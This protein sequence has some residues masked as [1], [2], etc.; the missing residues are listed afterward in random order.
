[1]NK[2]IIRSIKNR[3]YIKEWVN[4]TSSSRKKA[5]ALARD[6]GDYELR[7]ELSLLDKLKL[8][9][10]EDREAMVSEAIGSQSI[11]D[12]I[13]GPLVTHTFDQSP[14]M[15]LAKLFSLAEVNE[16]L[17]VTL[18]PITEESPSSDSCELI[19]NYKDQFNQFGLNLAQSLKQMNKWRCATFGIVL[20][21]IYLARRWGKDVP[22][23]DAPAT[24]QTVERLCVHYDFRT[25]SRSLD[26]VFQAAEQITA[27]IA[28]AEAP[29]NILSEEFFDWWQSLIKKIADRAKTGMGFTDLSEEIQAI[30]GAKSMKIALLVTD[31]GEPSSEKKTVTE[32]KPAPVKKTAIEKADQINSSLPKGKA[33]SVKRTLTRIV[34]GAEVFN[35]V[36][37]DGIEMEPEA[38]VE[39]IIACQQVLEKLKSYQ[40]ALGPQYY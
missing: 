30:P 2:E 19:E 28:G 39:Q 8:V 14:E 31:T 38:L 22:V 37:L 17:N 13:I 16:F 40:T 35:H 27:K 25:S 18:D 1:M 23:L 34:E 33:R 24:K 7:N 26:R 32:K 5:S 29:G 6:L 11:R 12:K 21:Y 4:D 36:D 10:P 9:A 20:A 3:N 15:R